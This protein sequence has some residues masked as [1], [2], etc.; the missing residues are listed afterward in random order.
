MVAA[1]R[2]LCGFSLWWMERA[3]RRD[4][5]ALITWQRLYKS[6]EGVKVETLAESVRFHIWDV[7]FP[8]CLTFIPEE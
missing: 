5:A 3:A 8:Y 6:V 4:S 7:G 2:Q 1:G